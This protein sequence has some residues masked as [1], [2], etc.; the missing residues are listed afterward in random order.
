MSR[1]H[2]KINKKPTRLQLLAVV[3]ELQGLIGKARAHYRPREPGHAIERVEDA[4]EKAAAL[5]IATTQFEPPQKPK[6]KP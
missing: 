6:E 3:F 4:L 1:K 5:C 2:F